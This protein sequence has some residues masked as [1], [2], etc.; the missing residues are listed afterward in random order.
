MKEV[1]NGKVGAGIEEE[2]RFE[3]INL[4]DNLGLELNIIN[5]ECIRCEVIAVRDGLKLRFWDGKRSIFIFNL[6]RDRGQ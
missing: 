2:K 1:W 3:G 4:R 5:N 6:K